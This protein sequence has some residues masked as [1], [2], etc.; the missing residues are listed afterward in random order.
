MTMTRK[1]VDDMKDKGF[2]GSGGEKIEGKKKNLKEK[3]CKN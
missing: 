3:C 2:D 1:I